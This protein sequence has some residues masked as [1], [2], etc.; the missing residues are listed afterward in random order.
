[1]NL[2]SQGLESQPRDE[3]GKIISFDGTGDF[4]IYRSKIV[5]WAKAVGFGAVF[6]NNK[7]DIPIKPRYAMKRIER[8]HGS[9]MDCEIKRSYLKDKIR[10]ENICQRLWQGLKELGVKR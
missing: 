5:S 6:R 10:W 1:M 3:N 2:N 4:W 9:R 8:N 7:D